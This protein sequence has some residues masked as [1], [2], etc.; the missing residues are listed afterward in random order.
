MPICFLTVTDRVY[1]EG[2]GW[3]FTLVKKLLWIAVAI[4]FMSRRRRKNVKKKKKK[5]EDNGKYKLARVS[6]RSRE[7]C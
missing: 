3:I 7:K 5:K 4:P 2:E 1:S 6:R